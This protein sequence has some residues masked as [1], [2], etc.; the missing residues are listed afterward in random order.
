MRSP[1]DAKDISM[2]IP[3]NLNGSVTKRASVYNF[4]FGSIVVSILACHYCIASDRGSIPRQRVCFF[5]LFQRGDLWI[6]AK[7]DSTEILVILDFGIANHI[8]PSTRFAVFREL[9]IV[10]ASKP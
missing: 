9:L 6:V 7:V 4:I 2:P 1:F 5:F 8:V 10:A 3:Q